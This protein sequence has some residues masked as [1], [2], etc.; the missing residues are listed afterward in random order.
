M[1]FSNAITVDAPAD[2]LF[3]FL[4]DIERVAPCLPGARIDGRDG[5]D[6]LGSMQVKVGPIV[7]SYQGSMRFVELDA[8]ARRAVMTA[9]ADEA[10]GNGAAEAR[11]TTAIEEVEGGSRISLETD[12]QV[13]GRVAQFGRGAMEKISERMLQQ[14]AQNLQAAMGSDAPGAP[15]ADGAPRTAPAAATPG[16]GADPAPLDAFGLV[17]G[18]FGERGRAVAPL[19][20]AAILGV[21]YGYLVGRLRSQRRPG[22]PA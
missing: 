16:P 17:S 2:E 10:R 6:Y 11:I 22:S 20:V 5:E 15:A 8:S 18:V 3:A 1:R 13:R 19:A 12:L 4:S 21:L 14:F 7:A 9:R